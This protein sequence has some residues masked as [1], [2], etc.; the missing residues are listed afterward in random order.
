MNCGIFNAL[1]INDAQNTYDDE[2]RLWEERRRRKKQ[3][4]LYFGHVLTC[5]N[6]SN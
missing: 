1:K 4:H 3:F 5:F 2:P 6:R